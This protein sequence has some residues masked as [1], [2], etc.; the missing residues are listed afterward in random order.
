MFNSGH[1][2]LLDLFCGV[3]GAA[4]GYH[5]A[6]FEV[7]GVDHKPQP[8][9]PFELHCDDAFAYLE[10]HGHEFDAIHASPPCQ[11]Y[12]VTKNAHPTEAY[13]DLL[14]ITLH[15][16]SAIQTPWVVE[17]VPGS[18][19]KAALLLCGT[20]F[21]LRIKRH[22]YFQTNWPLPALAP[23]SCNHSELLDM[24]S[25]GAS[26]NGTE[27]QYCDEMGITWAPVRYG[28][29][30]YAATQSIPPA[31]TEFIGRQLMRIVRP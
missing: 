26:R 29:R 17:N 2:R 24:Y 11:A 25:S 13:P 21:G 1:P 8:R 27:R 15:I 10:K 19:I 16:L 23:A 30:R 7:V 5:R 6:G 12:S 20:M 22:R 14:P 9:F 31:Y 18:P 4:M 28:N 3:G